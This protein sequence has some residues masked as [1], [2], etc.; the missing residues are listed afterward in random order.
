MAAAAGPLAVPPPHSF[1][2]AAHMGLAAARQR[3]VLAPQ[4]AI[5]AALGGVDPA[6]AEYTGIAI[7]AVPCAE[8]VLR[9]ALT[10]VHREVSNPNATIVLLNTEVPPGGLT[11]PALIRRLLR[12]RAQGVADFPVVALAP[13]A[14]G[15]DVRFTLL[16]GKQR[17][18]NYAIVYIAQGMFQG[19]VPAVAHYTF[20]QID[21]IA[22]TTYRQPPDDQRVMVYTR[23]PIVAS[24]QVYW[25]CEPTPENMDLFLAAE[26]A[27]NACSCCHQVVCPHELAW[28]ARL[29]LTGRVGRKMTLI[30]DHVLDGIDRAVVVEKNTPPGWAVNLRVDD[31]VSVTTPGGQCSWMP[32]VWRRTA[33]LN[34]PYFMGWLPEVV[35]TPAEKHYWRI[36][37]AL[38]WL[39]DTIVC[40][41]KMYELPS[42]VEQYIVPPFVLEAHEMKRKNVLERILGRYERCAEYIRTT[43]KT[44]VVSAVWRWLT[45]EEY[46]PVIKRVPREVKTLFEHWKTDPFAPGGRDHILWPR[47]VATT[48]AQRMLDWIDKF[49][50]IPMSISRL[51]RVEIIPTRNRFPAVWRFIESAYMNVLVKETYRT[52]VWREFRNDLRWYARS[53]MLGVGI[54]M[55]VVY[56]LRRTFREHRYQRVMTIAPQYAFA[57]K[58]GLNL[59]FPREDELYTRL[60]LMSAPTE[61]D[62]VD[63]VRRILNEEKWPARMDRMEMQTWISRVVTEPG[64]MAI[65]PVPKGRCLTCREK[66]KTKWQECKDCKRK[67][68]MHP[69]DGLNYHDTV[70]VYIGRVGIWSRKAE[71]P[72]IELKEDARL[73]IGK[74]LI[75]KMSTFKRW[76]EKQSAVATCRGWNAGP[77]FCRHVPECFPKGQ[78]T[79]LLA[80][81][82]RMA[83]DRDHEAQRWLYDLVY[84]MTKPR[85]QP[86]EPEGRDKFLSHFS[87]EKL[88]KM[89][90]AE[91]AIAQG[92]APPA[93]ERLKCSCFTKAEKS[94]ST[95]YVGGEHQM[96]SARKP[97]L[98][99]APPPVVLRM[100][101]PYTHRQTKWLSEEF[102]CHD[103]LF[104]AGCATPEE[105]DIYLNN[106]RRECEDWY[107]FVDDI[108]AIDANHS[109]ESFRYHK[110]VRDEQFPK[111]PKL[112]E[113]YWDSFARVVVRNGNA[114]GCADWVNASGVPDT[115]YK[116]SLICLFVRVIALANIVHRLSQLTEG[117]ARDLIAEVASIVYSSASG[118]D[119]YS[120]VPGKLLGVDTT[121]D[122]ARTAYEMLWA[123]AG[124]GV[125][126]AVVPPH[127]W[128]MATYLAARPTWAGDHY[129]WTPEPARRLKMS[130]WQID[131]SLHPGAWGRG[132]A[133]QLR[134]AAGC[135]PVIRPI[136]E[137]Y[138]RNT[139][140]PVAEVVLSDNPYNPWQRRKNVYEVTERA[141]REFCLDYNVTLKEYDR[142]VG[143]LEQIATVYVDLSGHLLERVFAEES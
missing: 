116:N 142:F 126:L 87:G 18:D 99:C 111:L 120:V 68:R 4:D 65:E 69:P 39:T 97:R 75:T 44:V 36:K 71:V 118:D 143:L 129:V 62:V 47:K 31:G 64:Q 90:E 72:D 96:K 20:M 70:A 24:R 125:K 77:T 23:L 138:L 51:L 78:A 28:E 98:I 76:Y 19:N 45:P 25:R 123:A 10:L 131:S 40:T 91:V 43:V 134:S 46:T 53:T 58:S 21:E 22:Q 110:R 115:S 80:F 54:A 117:N 29:K 140:G 73:V 103:R 50:R 48:A 92:D 27:H 30:P 38:H 59:P 2:A 3:P 109:K 128:R 8:S 12:M 127:K 13:R 89:L 61:A 83:R 33:V 52:Q 106:T 67:R 136:A 37:K 121:T 104:Y 60:A 86:L 130:W 108:T 7:R 141:V 49:P 41:F 95:E 102:G 88:R 139:S 35:L 100:V 63:R 74:L 135:N 122:E 42:R 81:M 105:L 84:V 124:F 132:I 6:F 112:I 17:S 32:R 101:G 107:I 55:G 26:K 79:A 34:L 94:L 11:V 66:K 82:I 119:G 14:P 57:S 85:L 1:P 16:H 5:V 137:W 114:R 113:D 15:D 9:L 133:V 93:S 56:I